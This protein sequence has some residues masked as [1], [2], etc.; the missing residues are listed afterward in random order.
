MYLAV[1]FD[2]IYC[3]FLSRILQHPEGCNKPLRNAIIKKITFELK[4]RQGRRPKQTKDE[5]KIYYAANHPKF[6]WQFV[7]LRLC[8]A[9]KIKCII[10]PFTAPQLSAFSVLPQR[11]AP[12]LTLPYPTP[13]PEPVSTS[14]LV[15]VS[16]YEDL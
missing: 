4:E 8:T 13:Q 16:I 9:R 1:L 2:S 7:V 10:S 3:C 15:T 11:S 6:M 5:S 12:H 14:I